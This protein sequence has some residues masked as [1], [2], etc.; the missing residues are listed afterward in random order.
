L[1]V[2]LTAALLE[3]AP[4]AGADPLPDDEEPP[5][6]EEELDEHAARDR[7][8]AT[9]APPTVMTCCLRRSSISRFL[10][11]GLCIFRPR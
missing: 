5:V 11:M 4:A 10:L 9:T 1:R 3:D 7:A 2:P 8:I 6:G